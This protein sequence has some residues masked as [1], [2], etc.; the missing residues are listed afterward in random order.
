MMTNSVP[1]IYDVASEAGV[2][3]ATVSR[4]LNFPHRVN[5]DTRTAVI[6]A[7]EK[8]GYVPKAESR[9]RA[10]MGTRRIG[11]L[12]PFFTEPSFVQRLR[13]IASVLSKKDYEMVVYPVDT[14]ERSLGFL[15]TLPMRRM[16]DGLIILSQVIEPSISKRLMDNH[17]ETVTI[18]CRDSHFTSLEI[19]DE[20]GGELATQYLIDKGYQRIAFIG[21]QKEPE[22]GVDPISK[23]MAGY[24]KAIKN[25]GLEIPDH[26]IYEYV[27]DHPQVL[28]ELVSHGLPLAI[29]AATDLQAIAMMKE[30]RL[31]GLRIPEDIAIIGFDNID[32]ADFFGLTTV[33]QPLD[34][35]GRIAAS[36]LISRLSNP[37][38]S[39]QHIELPLKIIQRESS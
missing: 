29:F 7:I 13:G 28:K 33:H 21:G 31:I 19:N 17:L 16:L 26:F 25:A 2:S 37:S 34:E 4:V 11:V 20:K 10:L 14:K 1:T 27:F 24:K 23:R 36:L 22:F 18:E 3:I 9:A 5:A 8:L 38:Q 35:S 32:V 6:N 15:E 39:T 12:I 30:T